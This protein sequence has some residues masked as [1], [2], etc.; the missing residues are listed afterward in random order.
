MNVKHKCPTCGNTVFDQGLPTVWCG[1]CNWRG[2]REQC[3]A[4]CPACDRP[5]AKGITW[6]DTGVACPVRR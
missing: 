2:T 4:I 5:V 6:I 3:Q 1:A